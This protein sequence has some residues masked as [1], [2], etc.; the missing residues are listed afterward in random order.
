[1]NVRASSPS[2]DR[3][4]FE[5]LYRD[6]HDPWGFDTSWY[7]RRKYD[8]TIASLPRERYAV[9]LEAG[10]ANGALS[11]RL[12]ERCDRL[13]AF[14]FIGD[15]VARARCRLAEH[16]HVCV[17]EATFPDYWPA[18]AVDL[19]VWSEIAYYL[20]DS[21]SKIALACLDKWLAAE[22][23]LVAVH[24]L[25]ETNYPRTGEDI[26]RWLDGVPWLERIVVHRDHS[27]ELGV[28]RKHIG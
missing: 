3:Q 16:R 21:A 7:E 4:Y 28:W 2:T 22:G 14:D 24:Y 1:M 15:A 8:L 12:A 18:Q 5:D 26:G 17:L 20:S 19:V 6:R 23:D 27:F 10:C 11:V 13:Y 9:G 25:G